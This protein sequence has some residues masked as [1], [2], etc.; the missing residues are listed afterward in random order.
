[1]TRTDL[2]EIFEKHNKLGH[3]VEVGV[4]KG[5]YAREI[6]SAYTGHLYL[7]DLWDGTSLWVD[8]SR[9]QL[10]VD[11]MLDYNLKKFNNYTKLKGDSIEMAKTFENK[12]LD[13]VY[14]DADHQFSS[15]LHDIVAWLPKVRSGGIISG[16]DYDPYPPENFDVKRAVDMFFKEVHLTEE[17]PRSWWVEVE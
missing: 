13:F 3:G 6:L 8:G 4:Y 12:S 17:H 1:M 14:I 5:F 15:V 7:V 10:V 16:H 2:V 9:S 11:E